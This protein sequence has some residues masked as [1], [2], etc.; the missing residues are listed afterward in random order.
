MKKKVKHIEE[1]RK[2]FEI[3]V[4][5]AEVKRCREDWFERFGRSARVPGF[6]PGKAPRDLLEKHYGERVTKEVI[7]DLISDAYHK[8]LEEEGFI[9]LGLPQITDVKL[10][11]KDT[12]SFKAEFDIRPKVKLGV[13]KGLKLNKKRIELKEDDIQKSVKAL[14]ELSARFKDVPGRAVQIGDYIVC[15]SEILIEGKPVGKK[16]ENIWMLIDEK[17]YIPG[18]SKSLVGV[19]ISEEKEIEAVLP[20]DFPT[21]EFANKKAVFKIKVK[22]IKEKVLPQIDDEFAKDLGY[23]N[24]SEL[25]ESVK[26]VLTEQAE[27]QARNELEHQIFEK[28]LEG[29]NFNVPSSLVERQ[30]EYLIEQEKERLKKQGL[31]EEDIQLREKELRERL[32]PHAEKQ[33]KMM[34][35][36]DEIAKREN[37]SVS[38]EELKELEKYY[39]DKELISNLYV[40]IRNGK[41]L[42]LLIKEAEITDE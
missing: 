28:L 17:S 32:G 34:F 15:D 36:M 9:A 20:E 1:C 7:E 30:R 22:E 6:R 8:A 21:K 5:P 29:A 2:A 14:Q 27:R 19:N 38:D 18:L 4:L 16:R 35:I 11:V 13:Y 31:K 33:V 41:I 12:L 42:D 3:E 39:K 26:K 24:L 25:N 40:E 23:N 37:I 10:D